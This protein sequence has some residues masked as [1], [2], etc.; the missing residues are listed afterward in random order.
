[1]KRLFLL[2]VLIA[3]AWAAGPYYQSPAGN[4]A[5]TCLGASAGLACKSM[6]H[7][8]SLVG[9]GETI[10]SRG[11]RNYVPTSEAGGVITIPA[12]LAACSGNP[13]TWSA[14][15][16]GSGA[17]LAPKVEDDGS[18]SSVAVIN[19]AAATGSYDQTT[20]LVTASCPGLAGAGSTYGS[21]Q[22]PCGSG[23]VGTGTVV[24]GVVTAITVTSPGSG[25]PKDVVIL[26]QSGEQPT[27]TDL[28][29]VQTPA[30]AGTPGCVAVTWTEHSNPATSPGCV[31]P[32]CDHWTSSLIG[33]LTYSEAN[34]FYQV[35]GSGPITRR[36]GPLARLVNGIIQTADTTMCKAAGSQGAA[37][38]AFGWPFGG[39]NEGTLGTYNVAAQVDPCGSYCVGGSVAG[40]SCTNN[41]QC[42][43][44]GTCTSMPWYGGYTQFEWKNS[45]L[46]VMDT[47]LSIGDISVQCVEIWT[48]CW[49]RLKTVS[50]GPPKLATTY[51]S[52]STI[53]GSN[54]GFIPGHA[55]FLRNRLLDLALSQGAGQVYLNRCP[56]GACA[57]APEANWQFNL[58]TAVTVGENPAADILY[59]AQSTSQHLFN[60]T[61]S[62]NFNVWGITFMG[63][64][65]V[66][67][68]YPTNFGLPDSQGQP[69]VQDQI[70]IQ[71]SN[72][73][74]FVANTF[75]HMSG[76]AMGIHGNSNNFSMLSN[77]FVDI[78]GGAVQIGD[79]GINTNVCTGGG[80]NV[81][82]NWVFWNNLI[83]GVQR[84]D[85]TGESVGFYVGDTH[86][87]HAFYNDMFGSY[88]GMANLGHFLN[89]GASGGQTAGC[90]YE[91]EFDH[92]SLAGTIVTAPSGVDVSNNTDHGLTY[93]ASNHSPN[94][95]PPV[96]GDPG[97]I[98]A[99]YAW[100]FHDNLLR[101]DAS[102]INLSQEYHSDGG[103]YGDQ[104]TMHGAFWNNTVY[105]I[106]QECLEIHTPSHGQGTFGASEFLPEHMFVFGNICGGNGAQ[107]QTA[108]R[109]WMRG[110]N[111]RS[112]SRFLYNL[113]LYDTGHPQQTR[114]PD[115]GFMAAFDFS[116]ATILTTG[117]GCTVP[118]TATISGCTGATMTFAVD[119][120][121]LWASAVGAGG[122]A[123]ASPTVTGWTTCSVNPTVT[124]CTSAGALVACPPVAISPSLSLGLYD[125]N[126]S[127]DARGAFPLSG[128]CPT[129]SCGGASLLT[130]PSFPWPQ[131]GTL[132]GDMS[133]DVN[134]M[135]CDPGFVAVKPGADSWV[136]TSPCLDLI[137]WRYPAYWKAGRVAPFVKVSN[138]PNFWPT[139][140]SINQ[141]DYLPSYKA[142]PLSVVGRLGTSLFDLTFN[143]SSSCSDT[144][145]S[146]PWCTTVPP[147]ITT[148][149]A[150]TTAQTQIVTP[151]PE[152]VNISDIHEWL[153][154]SG[155][156]TKLLAHSQ[157]WWNC[158][159][160]FNM[161]K[162]GQ[163]E[164]VI[165]AEAAKMVALG[166]YGQVMDWTGLDS[167]RTCR[168]AVADAWA[169]YL[170]THYNT[171]PL[172][173]GIMMDGNGVATSCATG[174]VDRTACI[175]GVLE[176]WADYAKLK[177][178]TQPWYLMD[179]N[180]HPMIF[181]FIDETLWPATNWNTV[182][183]NVK[184][185]T[186]L[187]ANS[188]H[189][190]FQNDFTHTQLDGS[191][192]WMANPQT[193]DVA[194]QFWWGDGAGTVPT[195][196]NNFYLGCIANPTLDC[197]GIAKKG[198][199]D[200]FG[201][202]GG[203]G[204]AN[205]VQAQRCAHTLKDTM[206]LTNTDMFSLAHI[207]EWLGIPWDDVEEGTGAEGGVDSC[208]S[209][210]TATVLGTVVSWSLT[211]TDVTYSNVNTL[212][213][214]TAY[215][216]KGQ[217]MNVALA[218]I[219]PSATSIDLKN[220]IPPGNWKVR[221]F[222][223]GKPLVTNQLSNSV[224]FTGGTLMSSRH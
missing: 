221:I 154:A 76:W 70:F 180:G 77:S 65:F 209:T 95:R 62:G 133:M 146:L 211:T 176:A 4:D 158:P 12:G 215:Y 42:T 101:D 102:D 30:C 9:C 212:H 47:S 185:Y 84:E 75:S 50:A 98:L 179:K 203:Y 37:N 188:F 124:L 33:G 201:F 136:P 190:E 130:N 164:V 45:D 67:D 34:I 105:R 165:A 78:W 44:G 191:Y 18:I 183:A 43:G 57:G 24:A 54:A 51:G 15:L 195:Y 131:P 204:G 128:N 108:T 186:N 187:Y 181:I 35:G 213:G 172:K 112:M 71:D 163:L 219:S 157:G 97:T 214:F 208:F 198:F 182:W 10:Y 114:F 224:N 27:F 49:L 149:P 162:D 29:I 52:A 2:L 20:L 110:T 69:L 13:V 123:C 178:T 160:H 8:L 107:P 111:T 79:I 121:H 39:I 36:G 86:H 81:P 32:N 87:W 168:L 206:D 200:G 14:Y 115:P 139:A 148:K 125:W 1:M 85:P 21:S 210:V 173:F 60:M 7:V 223:K 66:P 197:I 17:A 118:L 46:S 58:S 89:V 64:N 175:T 216:G 220:Y 88:T 177:Y 166:F 92:N 167:T 122:S 23:F 22:F 59:I 103:F 99:Q 93:S 161:G 109:V 156:V 207:L 159:G 145:Y 147:A 134:S 174:G 56:T 222:M 40:N 25:Y 41:G 126:M 68:P 218:D 48:D 55:Y 171:I 169:K 153:P 3:P 53:H 127:W 94:S 151:I 38:V 90:T 72:N 141:S 120:G 119:D 63:G 106:S 205:R 82:A 5:N 137:G 6:D 113:E 194:K 100:Q 140:S 144:G 80:Q 143:T 193:Y 73:F 142:R 192:T 189:Y 138:I 11:G 184:T 16:F 28:M 61:S 31:L 152:N 150:N 170:G 202:G 196:Y 83:L 104:G 116:E 19:G 96:N 117:S 129:S 91:W 74:S 199:D 26:A 135:N 155:S 217:G 132:S